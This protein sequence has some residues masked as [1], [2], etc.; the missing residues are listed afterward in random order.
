VNLS[1]SVVAFFR[2][3]SPWTFF[4]AYAFL[5][6]LPVPGTR[7]VAL[8]AGVLFGGLVGTGVVFVGALSGASIGF[9]LA[10]WAGREKVQAFLS[11]KYPCLQADLQTNSTVYLWSLRSSPLVSFVAVNYLMGVSPIGYAR[12]VSIT[13]VLSF[14]YSVFYVTLGSWA[15][16]FTQTHPH[17]FWPLIAFALALTGLPLFFR[18]KGAC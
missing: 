11:A 7:L 17:A 15:R 3:L 13:A 4:L 18:R 2:G 16:Q 12:F 9:F 14:C 8:S 5:T 1:E 6:T 10:R